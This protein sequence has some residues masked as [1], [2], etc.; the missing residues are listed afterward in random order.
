MLGSSDPIHSGRNC[1]IQ[2]PSAGPAITVRPPT[3]IAR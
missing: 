2:A 1:A 3:T